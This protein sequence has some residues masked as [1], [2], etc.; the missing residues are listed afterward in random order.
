MRKARFYIFLF[1]SVVF[2]AAVN[3]FA[4]NS[5]LIKAVDGENISYKIISEHPETALS[6]NNLKVELSGPTDAKTLKQIA[7]QLRSSRTQFNKLWILFYIKGISLNQGAWAYSHFKPEGFYLEIRVAKGSNIDKL[8]NIRIVRNYDKEIGR[9][10]DN[11]LSVEPMIIIYNANGK[12]YAQ[13]NYIDGSV[14]I[15]ELSKTQFNGKTRYNK[16]GDACG[17]YFI[18]ETNGSLSL[19]NKDGRFG[20]ARSLFPIPKKRESAK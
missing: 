6:K 15:D 8:K 5:Y 2:F 13:T 19:Y 7:V 18:L 9:W 1:A 11:T 4:A 17:E 14:D 3:T 12:V 16:A 20:E 10:V